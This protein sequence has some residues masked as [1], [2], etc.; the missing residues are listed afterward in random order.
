MEHT[1][2]GAIPE[3]EWN[4]HSLS[5][6]Y[7]ADQEADYMMIQLLGSCPKISDVA[8]PDAFWPRHE[9]S[10]SM[11]IPAGNY[12]RPDYALE[13]TNFNF[14]GISQGTNLFPTSS[15]QFYNL[16]DSHAT[17]VTKNVKSNDNSISTG[18]CAGEAKNTTSSY[19][20]EGDGD[21]C[22]N[23]ENIDGNMEESGRNQ[24]RE[25]PARWH[26]K[27][28]TSSKIN[29]MKRPKISENVSA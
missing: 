20:I 5:G 16:S 17:L 15:N 23:R 1:C 10:T 2:T 22:L 24:Q 4:S 29:S 19:L 6:M 21:Q 25:E 18:F 3:G 13:T 28:N 7:I 8:I 26:E 27:S 11:D 9:E 12:E 14:Y